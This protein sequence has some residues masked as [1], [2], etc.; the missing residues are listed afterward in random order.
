MN[1]CPCGHRGDPAAECH[2]T[3]AQVRCYRA[4]I[5]GPFLD[6][7]DLQVEV[8]RLSSRDFE[9]LGSRPEETTTAAAARVA[10]AR[11]LQRTRQGTCNARLTD[12]EVQ[13]WCRTDERGQ[14]VLAQAMDRLALSGRARQRVLRV[15][16]TIADLDDAPTVDVTHVGEALRLRTVDRAAATAPSAPCDRRLA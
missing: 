6:R 1:P 12:G 11:S 7:L 3:P 2:C 13:R 4:R 15:A 14:R 10:R 16:R 5:S 8:S 9:A